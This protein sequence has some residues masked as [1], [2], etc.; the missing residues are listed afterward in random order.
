ML[1]S[2]PRLAIWSLILPN[3]LKSSS[4]IADVSSGRIRPML[5]TR[6]AVHSSRYFN[7]WR[8][9][10]ASVSQRPRPWR[11]Q[12]CAVP[13]RTQNPPMSW[14]EQ[15]RPE[16]LR[17][18]TSRWCWPS[19]STLPPPGGDLQTRL[20]MTGS[21][22]LCDAELNSVSTKTLI[23]LHH[24]SLKISTTN[25]SEQFCIIP[26]I[27]PPSPAA[28]QNWS[29]IYTQTSPARLLSQCEGCL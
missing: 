3:L 11:Q 5:P 25:H 29:L 16:D 22:R 19:Y 20:T 4:L 21:K 24:N 17:L 8:H 27:C 10:D 2:G 18:S 28:K 6:V 15:W 9:T 7:T 1:H 14:N 26:S 23:P 12:V 13:A